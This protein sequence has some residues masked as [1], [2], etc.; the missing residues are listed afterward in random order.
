MKELMKASARGLAAI[1]V[2][3]ALIS[4]R[5]RAS[6]MGEN[7]ALVGSTQALSLVPGLCGQYVRRAF[8]AR[9]LR[10]GCASSAV[11]EFGTLFSQVDACI[12]EDVYVG[13]RCH[14]GHVHLE[15]KVLLAAGVHVP[16]GPHTHGTAVGVPMHDQPGRLRVV[17]IGA[18]S[19]IGSNAVILAD[20]GCDTVVGAGAVVTRPLPDRVIAAGVPARVVRSRGAVEPV[21][22]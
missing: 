18:G 7:R 15:R 5:I 3:P 22:A 13:P 17:R 12:E 20:V 4:F 8:L 11:V 1:A 6:I 14:L 21:S 2:V 9:A 16:S 19:W 10:G